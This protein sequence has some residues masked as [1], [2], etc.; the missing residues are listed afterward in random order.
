MGRTLKVRGNVGFK[1]EMIP[2]DYNICQLYYIWQKP[3]GSTNLTGATVDYI[4]HNVDLP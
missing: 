3:V 4:K 2:P 1:T